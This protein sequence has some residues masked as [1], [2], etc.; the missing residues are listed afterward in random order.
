MT[1]KE[2]LERIKSSAE[3]IE[4]PERLSPESIKRQLEK[5]KMHQ[6]KRK[7][8]G[9]RTMAVAAVLLLLCGTGLSALRQITVGG[10][11]DGA[12]GAETA[13]HM[14]EGADVA[15][16][17]A[18]DVAAG[19]AAERIKKTDAG[20]MYVVA[21]NY[22]EIYDLL[23]EQASGKTE[24]VFDGALPE[25]FAGT[26]MEET[27]VNASS[28]AIEDLAD[29]PQK[30]SVQE[31]A[32]GDTYTKT[33]VQTQGIDESDIIKTDGSYLYVVKEDTV[34]MIDIRG[35]KMQE[36]GEIAV[37]LNS[38]SDRV[39]EMYVD[40]DTLC[41]IVERQTTGLEQE[42]QMQGK[43]S[44]AEEVAVCD[45]Y[46]MNTHIETEL[47]TYD[48][49]DRKQAVFL[50]SS[51]Q[52]GS[53]KTSRKVG[54]I[55][56]LFT[57]KYLEMPELKKE[58]AVTEDAIAGWIPLV[59][60]QAVAADCIYLPNRGSMG[61][62]ISSV[63]VDKP[64]R[65]VDYA[66]ILNDYVNIY[67]GT[68]AIYLY[69][70][71]YEGTGSSTQFAKFSFQDGIIN[72]VGAASAAGEVYDTFA[73]NEYQGK[74]R[75]LTTDWS[76]KEQENRLFIF[77]EKLNLLGSLA[78]IARGEQIYA[79]RYLGDM[80]YF[81]TYRNTDPLFAVDL[82]DEKNPKILSE[83]K[84]TGF[85]EYLHF[86][87][88]DKLVGIGYETNPDTG[89]QQ[90]VKL[91]MFDISNPSALTI[92]GSVV[93]KNVDYSPALYQYKCVLADEEENLIG[94]AVSDY[95]KGAAGNSYRLFA[96]ENGEFQTLLSEEIG[97][98]EELE[99]YRGIYV[100]DVFY[101]VNTSA[102]VSYDRENGYK[103]IQE[104]EW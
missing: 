48:I 86:W 66:L 54:N 9:R 28:G 36:A 94:F 71:V 99:K 23:E 98:K 51:V 84:I 22:G 57:E 19:T 58:Q 20:E 63:D 103:K 75:L 90:G 47:R 6:K 25:S 70:A 3:E 77:D 56:Y 31:E 1:E 15:A 97:E 14:A 49:S 17:T 101:L 74:L 33:N 82:S 89:V 41:L 13:E 102:A 92:A 78:G 73:V 27:Q 24:T 16:G 30:E 53:Y 91:T 83:L 35:A 88:E 43:S 29:M 80:A 2:V 64:D 100:G 8:Y 81:V 76:G 34:K 61:L 87:G 38:A 44:G 39:A 85:S 7:I 26:G 55:V 59:N 95:E 93:L 5:E 60:A 104:L 67:V 21:E 4:V 69:Q 18:A 65:V 37:K 10:G 46:Y 68:Q 72:A 42:K 11:A 40:G 52:D 32:R 79:A 50:G 62:L 12:K 96:W 45:V